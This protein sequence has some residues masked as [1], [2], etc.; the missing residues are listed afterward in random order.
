MTILEQTT[1][2]LYKNYLT[3]LSQS[4]HESNT[5]FY[6][7]PT[8]NWPAVT[9]QLY[10]LIVSLAEK[11]GHLAY[12]WP[13]PVSL[14]CSILQWLT[15]FVGP[16]KNKTCKYTL[17]HNH[18]QTY[19]HACMQW[20]EQASR[21]PITT[22]YTAASNQNQSLTCFQWPQICHQH[23]FTIHN[24]S[25]NKLWLYHRINLRLTTLHS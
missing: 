14:F 24:G 18:R 20:S 15:S 17:T 12:T 21:N 22:S 19:M 11:Q 4:W 16:R 13:M 10:C 3:I 2:S 8:I 6:T 5:L 25:L 23:K 1:F 9:D 7:Q